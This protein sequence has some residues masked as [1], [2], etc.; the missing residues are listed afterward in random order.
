MNT[1]DMNTTIPF[2]RMHLKLHFYKMFYFFTL[3]NLTVIHP[4]ISINSKAS[5]ICQA[6]FTLLALIFFVLHWKLLNSHEKKSPNKEPKPDLENKIYIVHASHKTK[7]SLHAFK[8][9]SAKS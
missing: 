9:T 4:A 2:P 3:K 7:T 1:T 8:T 5:S 6:L